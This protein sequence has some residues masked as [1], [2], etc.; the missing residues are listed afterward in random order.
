MRKL[1]AILVLISLFGSLKAQEK[2]F[3]LE[4][5][6]S[7]KNKSINSYK[8]SQVSY[9]DT[10]FVSLPFLDDFSVV[11]IWPSPSKW[12]DNYVY[13]NTDYAKHSP[14]VGVA[15]FDA[16]DEDGALYS[17]AGPYQFEADF[18]TSQP[19]R[20]D[21]LF[22]PIQRA[23]L[24]SDSLYLSFFYQPQGKGSMPAKKDSLVLEFH[25]PLE[26]DTIVTAE[27]TVISPH[28]QYK[29]SS[30]G[31]TQVDTF[32]IVHGQYFNQVLIPIND[33][34]RY[35]KKGFRFRFR[36]Y[37]S[38]AN[39]YVPDWQSNGDQWNLD[40]VYLNSGRSINDTI[41]KDVAFA[42]R[43][44]SMLAKYEAMPYTQ[45]GE[46]FVNE[47][48]DTLSIFIANLDNSPQNISYRYHVQKDSQLPF[49]TYDGGSYSIFPFLTNSYSTYQPF[50]RPIV[51]F[52]YSPFENQ[53]EIVFHTT[54][55]L[56]TDPAMIIQSNDTIRYTQVF[57]NYYAYDDG[58]AE[59]GIGLNGAAGS[60]AVRFELNTMDTLRA[61]KIFFNQ[62]RS[63]AS[64][65]YIDI[66]IWNDSFGKPGTII[67][68]LAQVNPLYSDSL[69]NFQTYWFDEPLVIE[70]VNFPGL[71]FYAGW[72]QTAI[73]NL[74]VGLDRYNDTHQ[75]RFYNV[76]GTW[77]SSDEQHAGSLLLRPV[78]GKA[79]PV[80]MQE[81]LQTGQLAIY[82]NPVAN[83]NLNI[84]LP[85]NLMH[86]SSNELS[87]SVFNSSG[88]RISSF[89]YQ[90][91]INIDNWLPGLYVI[92]LH[93]EVD[94]KIYFGKVIK[95]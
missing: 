19:I 39:N 52:L 6:K 50:A 75:Y 76:D 40:L 48:K 88:I 26:F 79:N 62:I 81:N 25:S 57:S 58:T 20:L 84:R 65:K 17:S 23:I 18:L 3:A 35:F 24:K 85:I 83:G 15:T 28:W 14:T 34:I 46:N 86:H 27:D 95:K 74:N 47:M 82:P 70:P 77:Q 73:D 64:D 66:T 51:N 13:I 49:K 92:R 11:S 93:S 4:H 61:L 37:A 87:V 90:E 59:A 12:A 67:K 78:V 5:N 16:I 89:P 44:P 54:H 53:E 9:A 30:A 31:G 33:S 36:N 69:N 63:G 22:S 72:Q 32:A 8:D 80:S 41:I 94:G 2:M 21:S 91:T 7:V 43:A 71:I 55:Y 10:V 56:T 29:W 1:L 42:D 45:Y 38:L 60:Y 68:Q